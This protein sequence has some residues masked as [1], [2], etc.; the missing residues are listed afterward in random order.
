MSPRCPDRGLVTAGVV[1]LRAPMQHYPPQLTLPG[2]LYLRVLS[3]Q[4]SL[5]GGAE[6]R[7]LRLRKLGRTRAGAP[8]TLGSAAPPHVR[9]C[10]R[11]PAPELRGAAGALVPAL[12][13]AAGAVGLAPARPA[14]GPLPCVWPA[15]CGVSM[16]SSPLGAPGW[17]FPSGWKPDPQARAG[18][19]AFPK[20]GETKEREAA[21]LGFQPER[22]APAEPQS[23]GTPQGPG[24]GCLA[25]TPQGR[26]APPRGHC[27]ARWDGP[28]ADRLRPAVLAVSLCAL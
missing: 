23:P 22:P 18:G 16:V 25:P 14:G 19:N 21:S 5:P 11:R 7:K 26:P 27:R 24:P 3:E 17:D 6:S 13:P 4:H 20:C 12:R 8:G 10:G 15:P 2:L 28:G 1:G 9:A